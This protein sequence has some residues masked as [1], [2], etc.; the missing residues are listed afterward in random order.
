M[1]TVYGPGGGRSPGHRTVPS[2]LVSVVS[3]PLTYTYIGSSHSHF[4]SSHQQLLNQRWPHPRPQPL[5]TACL[6]IHEQSFHPRVISSLSFNLCS[7]K[8]PDATSSSPELLTIC[9]LEV[10]LVIGSWVL[11]GQ[12]PHIPHIFYQCTDGR[13]STAQILG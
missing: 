11:V 7:T 3:P 12:V 13:W 9:L 5:P 2:T 1:Y 6:G 4:P 10:E 8:V